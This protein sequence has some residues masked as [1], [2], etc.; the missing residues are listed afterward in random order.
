MMMSEKMNWWGGKK[1]EW[2][3]RTCAPSMYCRV[4]GDRVTVSSAGF[5]EGVGQEVSGTVDWQNRI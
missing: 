4:G 3:Q 5:T 1:G 2:G